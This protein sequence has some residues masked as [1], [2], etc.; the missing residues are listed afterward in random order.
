MHDFDHD[1]RSILLL[2]GTGDG[3]RLARLLQQQGWTVSVSV[4]TKAAARTYGDLGVNG[5]R[6][7]ALGDESG[8]ATLLQQQGPFRWVVDAGAVQAGDTRNVLPSTHWFV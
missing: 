1:T 5:I 2:A 8:I 3:P 4:V 7:G 6:I